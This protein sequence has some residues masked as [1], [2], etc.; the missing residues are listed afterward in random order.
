LKFEAYN[1]NFSFGPIYLLTK[2]SSSAFPYLQQ[3][4]PKEH[5]HTLHV[6]LT[7]LTLET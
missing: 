1:N 7:D 3:H 4:S 2:A 5:R 6:T